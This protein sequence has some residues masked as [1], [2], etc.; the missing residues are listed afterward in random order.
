METMANR[1]EMLIVK[2]AAGIGKVSVQLIYKHVANR[3]IRACRIGSSVRIDA[4]DFKRFMQW[5]RGEERPQ[6]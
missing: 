4:E 5:N 3:N 2:Q 6:D 1:R